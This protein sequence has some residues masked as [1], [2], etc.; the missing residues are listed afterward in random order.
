LLLLPSLALAGGILLWIAW[1]RLQNLEARWRPELNHSEEEKL[2]KPPSFS[3]PT[4]AP[5]TKA[6][7]SLNLE[8]GVAYPRWYLCWDAGGLGQGKVALP[9]GEAILL[10]R[11]SESHLQVQ[12]EQLSK[13]HLQFDVRDGEVSV[14]DLG[15]RNGSWLKEEQ[16]ERRRLEPGSP[17]PFNLRQELL[18]SEPPVIRLRLEAQ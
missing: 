15:S 8:S 6:I 16:G 12:L 5:R 7:I 14:M 2:P 9:W 4:L 13:R 1:G 17:E 10:G 3:N 18:L 11:A